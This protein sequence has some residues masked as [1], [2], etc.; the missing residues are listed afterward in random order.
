MV[1]SKQHLQF[2][3]RTGSNVL[4]GVC[5]VSSAVAQGT[6]ETKVVTDHVVPNIKSCCGGKSVYLYCICDYNGEAIS[7][8]NHVT[9]CTVKK[10]HTPSNL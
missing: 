4:T 6:D 9:A 2:I 8:P 7:R 5:E 1:K 3:V 10:K